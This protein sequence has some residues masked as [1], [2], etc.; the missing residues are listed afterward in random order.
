MEASVKQ[1]CRDEG[2]QA[3]ADKLLELMPPAAAMLWLK[4]YDGQL[5]GAQ[6]I[7][8][9]QLEGSGPVLAALLAF[10]EGAFA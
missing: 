1:A 5:G 9:L 7:V 4:G 3:V 6:P 2:A 8:V 10:E